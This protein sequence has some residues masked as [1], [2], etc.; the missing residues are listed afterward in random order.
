MTT[1]RASR[2]SRRLAPL[3]PLRVVDSADAARPAWSDGLHF[4]LPRALVERLG[5][6]DRVEADG[7]ITIPASA[8]A[9]SQA[10]VRC[11]REYAAFTDRAPL[12][13][14]LPVSYRRV[15]AWAR[16]KVAAAIGR[17]RRRQQDAWAAFPGWPVDLT[18]DVLA[19]LAG[20][21]RVDFGGRTPVLLTHDID[22][23]EGLRRLVKE[24]LPREEAVAARSTSYVVPCAWPLDR[25]LLNEAVG[26]GHALGVHGYDHRNRT[27]FLGDRARARRLDAA[28]PFIERYRARGYRAPSLL[29]TRALL[30]DLASRYEY[31]SS[32][33]TSGG[34]FPAPNNGCATARPFVL[35]GII[36]IPVTLPR[37]GSLRFLGYSPAEILRVWIDCADAIARAGGVVVLLT[38]C[39]GRFSG[40]APMLAV[41]G[42]FLEY[43]RD[44]PSRYEFQTPDA[45]L[46][47]I[48]AALDRTPVAG[49]TGGRVG[50]VFDAATCTAP[51]E[52]AARIR[53]VVL[54]YVPR[55]RAVTILDVGCGAGLLLFQL[56]DAL[57]LARCVGV[58]ISSA[59]IRT[60]E[61]AR[62]THRAAQRIRFVGADYL[63]FDTDPVDVIVTDTALHFF[64]GG[65]ERL[66]AK[67][68]RDVRPSGVLVCA[69][70]YESAYNRGIRAVRR[71]LVRVR[72]GPVDAVV[73]GAA[74]LVHGR[75]LDARGLS[76][77]TAYMYIPPTQFMT[78]AI[79]DRL[80]PSLGLEA[81]GER[82]VEA[83]SMT[84]LVQRVTVFVKRG[85]DR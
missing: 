29:R 4:R 63:D 84:Q 26:R 65:A 34:L 59:S 54:E 28:R 80:A 21:P 2:G 6:G 8:E 49:S 46:P 12:S 40:N 19:D 79:R 48:A 18:A 35:E 74:R 67:L 83:A 64:E 71:T 15:P 16:S 75:R 57:P 44:A 22:S 3:V 60:A 85:P 55:D 38:H 10:E 9:V 52:R 76:E 66:W 33:P 14:R 25:D 24:F 41:Y 30:R 1:S 72:S 42:R 43:I 56:A 70:A 27:P 51:A 36:E 82:D 77:R 58:D 45:L 78:P 73:E 37:D 39:E 50:S 69:M 13:A 32:I 81:I 68:S 17:R 23:A 7:H 20:V 31:D 11:V 5:W 62:A 61:E 47:R 53:D